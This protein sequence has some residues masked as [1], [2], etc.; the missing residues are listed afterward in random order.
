MIKV[1]FLHELTQSILFC[2][3]SI[4]IIVIGICL[5]RYLRARIAESKAQAR[6]LERR[7]LYVRYRSDDSGPRS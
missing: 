7:R 4:A 1:Y 5:L 2:V 6:L 3:L